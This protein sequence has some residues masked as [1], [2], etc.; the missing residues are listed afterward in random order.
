M[1]KFETTENVNIYELDL[2]SGDK[3]GVKVVTTITTPIKVTMRELREYIKKHAVPVDPDN[4]DDGLE[5]D[6]DAIGLG[7]F[8]GNSLDDL[9]DEVVDYLINE[10]NVQVN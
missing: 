10:L 4:P 2:P 8:S 1:I 3:A 9:V 5:F 7:Y 6:G